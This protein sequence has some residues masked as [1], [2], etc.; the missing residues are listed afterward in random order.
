MTGS[1]ESAVLL[2]QPSN[3]L[4]IRLGRSVRIPGKTLK[5]PRHEIFARIYAITG[6][7]TQA[8]IEAGYRNG[9][10]IEARKQGSRLMKTNG[11]I[12]RRIE[13]IRGWSAK[14]S[15]MTDEELLTHVT[16]IA[17]NAD[18]AADKINASKLIMQARGIAQPEEKERKHVPTIGTLQQY[19]L[20][21]SETK[22]KEITEKKDVIEYSAK[23]RASPERSD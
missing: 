3:W 19:I 8:A 14:H 6:N 17:I 20:N 15:D 16:D 12:Q 11:D 21:V 1:V 13:E 9:N 22:L 2:C 10:R 7:Q 23:E 5:N 4:S 18:R